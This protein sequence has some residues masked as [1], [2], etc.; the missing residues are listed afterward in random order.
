MTERDYEKRLCIVRENFACF[1]SDYENVRGDDWNDAPYDSNAG[2]PYKEFEQIEV[3]FDEGRCFHRPG[4]SWSQQ[5]YSLDKMR[6]EKI[7][8]IVC[9]GG[10]GNIIPGM[11][12]KAFIEII[13]ANGGAVYELKEL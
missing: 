9:T 7:P 11:T 13:K 2:W 1:V 5:H 3:Y 4:A 8:F 6:E 10:G 12:L